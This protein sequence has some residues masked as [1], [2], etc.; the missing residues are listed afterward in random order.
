[1]H[2]E[3]RGALELM[4]LAI[5]VAGV[6][7]HANEGFVEEFSSHVATGFEKNRLLGGEFLV[8]GVATGFLVASHQRAHQW[9][10]IGRSGLS[11][12][13]TRACA[14]FIVAG[15]FNKFV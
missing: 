11:M 12:K 9:C 8:F 14:R 10:T 3:Y 6:I 15:V 13:N 5:G 7:C 1:M 4:C 2:G